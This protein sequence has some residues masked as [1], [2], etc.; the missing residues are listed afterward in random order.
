MILTEEYEVLTDKGFKSFG[1]IRYKKSSDNLEIILCDG[2]KITVTKDHKFS[3]DSKEVIA[4]NLVI[5]DVLKTSGGLEKII[6]IKNK[7]TK[8]K[9]YDLLEVD[10]GNVYYT[11]NILSHNCEFLGSGGS[12]IDST[13]LKNLTGNPP[14]DSRLEGNFEIL[15][16]PI[17]DHKYILIAD[18]SEGNGGDC[19]TCQVIDVTELPYKQ[20]SAYSD[21]TMKLEYFHDVI[22]LIGNY[23]N[24]ALVI[25]ETNNGGGEVCRNLNYEAE[26]E[27]QFYDEDF[28]LKTTKLTKRLGC[29]HFK[30]LVES[31]QLI[32]NHWK[33]IEQL[34]G[35]VKNNKNSYSNE[36]GDDLVMPLI[37]FS[38]WINNKKFT[39]TWLDD[40]NIGRRLNKDKLEE[41][42]DLIPIYCTN[43]YE[44]D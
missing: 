6:K 31:N 39:D 10:D 5:G 16:L 35:F 2:E 25:I 21:N 32:L 12:L 29:S 8:I 11:N 37:I 34:G 40:D 3:V 19:A 4:N 44:E 27:N 1:G 28:G 9:V 26:Y 42:D 15:E 24:Q 38:Y 14:I 22:K 41:L 43:G 20:V 33:T 17:K 18:T 36:D 30:T 13:T 23:Y 7:K